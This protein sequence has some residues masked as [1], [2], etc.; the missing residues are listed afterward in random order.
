MRDW[1]IL[2]RVKCSQVMQCK[3]RDNSEMDKKCMKYYLY[4]D[5]IG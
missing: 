1:D 3:N 4:F 2:G 5:L